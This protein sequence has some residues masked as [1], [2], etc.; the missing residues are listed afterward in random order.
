M[1]IMRDCIQQLVTCSSIVFYTR[2]TCNLKMFTLKKI[3]IEQNIVY[4]KL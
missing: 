4:G 3:E 2:V 1:F